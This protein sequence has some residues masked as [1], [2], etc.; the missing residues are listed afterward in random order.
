MTS[1]WLDDVR[2]PPDGWTWCKTV[3]EAKALMLAGPVAEAS[4]D[5]DLDLC[6]ICHPSGGVDGDAQADVLPPCRHATTGYDFVVWMAEH[7]CWPVRKP[8][9]HSANPVGAAAMRQAID[10]YWRAP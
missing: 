1:L 8:F 7:K 6:P 4:L 10:R 5:H 9:V 2:L 3:E